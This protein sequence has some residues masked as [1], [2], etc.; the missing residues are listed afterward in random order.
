MIKNKISMQGKYLQLQD[1]MFFCYSKKSVQKTS[2][3]LLKEVSYYQYS[4]DI[5]DQDTVLGEDYYTEQIHTKSVEYN[6]YDSYMPH[7]YFSDL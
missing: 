2:N 1:N 5:Q 6:L 3:N 4:L 7:E